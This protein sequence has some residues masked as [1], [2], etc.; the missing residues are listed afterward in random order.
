MG[1]IGSSPAGSSEATTGD[2][3]DPTE[4]TTIGSSP[5]GSSKPTGA[6]STEASTTGAGST[7]ASATEAGSTKAST[8]EAVTDKVCADEEGKFCKKNEDRCNKSN[9]Q[10]RCPVMCD[11]C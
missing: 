1:T 5:A 8:T 11:A 10:E 3:S 2:S 6:G 7:T 9:V 4:P